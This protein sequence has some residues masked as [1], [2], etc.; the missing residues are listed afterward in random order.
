MFLSEGQV[1]VAWCREELQGGGGP[2]NEG[3]LEV[4]KSA[5]QQYREGMMAIIE[6]WQT[7][8]TDLRSRK[9]KAAQNVKP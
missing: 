9:R 8:L 1:S 2:A 7:A 6:S 5:V 3:W 4:D